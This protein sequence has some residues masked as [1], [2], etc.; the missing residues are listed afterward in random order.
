MS[1][2]EEMYTCIRCY[3]EFDARGNVSDNK[4]TVCPQC[5][6][7]VPVDDMNYFMYALRSTRV[8]AACQG[9]GH[10]LV[11]EMQC[12]TPYSLPAYTSVP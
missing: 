7:H 10:V 5:G 6:F 1:G 3:H 2:T 4:V 11:G 8:C 9:T 12:E